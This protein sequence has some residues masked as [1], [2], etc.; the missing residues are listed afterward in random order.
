MDI[1]LIQTLSDKAF[2]GDCRKSSIA[3]F[4]WSHLKITLNYSP[5]VVTFSLN[6][7]NL[8]SRP[9]GELFS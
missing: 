1:Q 6:L 4:A 9:E 7:F 3:I 2:K 5:W 8:L